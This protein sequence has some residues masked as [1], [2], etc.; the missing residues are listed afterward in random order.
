MFDLTFGL[1]L[2][3]W[4]VTTE[5]IVTNTI[6][7]DAPTTTVWDMLTNPAQTPKYMFGCQALSDWT[8]GSPLRWQGIY[9]GNELIFVTGTVVGMAPPTYLAYTTFDPNGTL[10]DLP[11]NYVTVT[12]SLTEANGKT[13]LTVTQGDFATVG[14]GERRYAEASNNGEGWN[15]ILVQIKALAEAA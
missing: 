4:A 9:E 3:Q 11:E 1:Y 13:R 12:Y 10:A 5:L 2:N 15:P 6:D 8:V 14:D 7:I